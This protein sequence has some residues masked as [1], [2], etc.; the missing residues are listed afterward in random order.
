MPA[1]RTTEAIGN[2]IRRADPGSADSFVT[3]RAMASILDTVGC[4]LAGAGSEMREPM[5]GFLQGESG[6]R[7]PIAGT[8]LR[9][10]PQV[11]A[12]VHGSFG[13]AL[14]FDDVLSMM[15]AHPSSV[16]LPALWAFSGP[17][18][19]D[20]KSTRLNSSHSCASRMPSSA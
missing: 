11:A 12:L 1:V 3:E 5:E 15:P 17:D 9:A 7:H 6:G 16:V 19:R 20:R 4:I 13:H 10:S 14:D 8:S 2:F 18:T